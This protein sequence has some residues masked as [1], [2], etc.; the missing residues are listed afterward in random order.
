MDTTTLS[1]LKPGEKGEIIR[2]EGEGE[3]RS[4]LSALGF[5]SGA[6]VAVLYSALF[7]GPRTYTIC[8][9]QVSLRKTEANL[10]HIGVPVQE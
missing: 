3:L 6:T 7:G 4:R 8:G 9:S 10:I 1:A 2:V 5:R